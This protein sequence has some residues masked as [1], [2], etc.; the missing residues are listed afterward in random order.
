MMNRV[1]GLILAGA[2]LASAQQAPPATP[3]ARLLTEKESRELYTRTIQLMEAG[4]FAIP[5]LA[6]AGLPLIENVKQT[7]ES[8][9]FLGWQ[10]PTLH[11][12]VLTNVRAYLLVSDAVPKPV[13]FPEQ[14]RKQLSELRD[15]VAQI[16][17]YF[18]ALV[19]QVQRQLRAPDRD[20]VQRYAE[21]NTTV[22]PPNAA[23][24]RVVF[25]GDSITDGWRLNE[26]FTGKDFINRGISGQITSQMLARMIPDVIALKPQAMIVLAGTN[27]IA[28][29]VAMKTIQNNLEA[30]ADLADKHG[31][32]VIF[33]TVLPISDYHKGVNPAYERSRQ[34]PPGVINELNGWIKGFC[35]KRGYVLANYFDTIKNS[36]GMLPADAAAD[37]LHPNAQGYRVMAPVALAAIEKS[38]NPPQP[39]RRKRRL[40]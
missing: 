12:R 23:N 4:G 28:R 25:M 1:L 21:A 3:G 9:Q 36:E 6:R 8:L 30:M 24:P 17:S 32:K 19:E 29:G 26:Y 11:Y 2:L 15:N 33:A 38:L 10:N 16:E 22:P 34:R 20:Q 27:D 37:G 31:I 5:D 35:E 39:E 13:P 18:Q 7:I 40:F 14:S